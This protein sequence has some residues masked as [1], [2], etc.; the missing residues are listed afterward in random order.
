MK[1]DNNMK[2]GTAIDVANEVNNLRGV[3]I[4]IS[5]DRNGPEVLI[6]RKAFFEMFQ[7]FTEDRLCSDNGSILSAKVC[8]V[9]FKAVVYD[10][11]PRPD[12]EA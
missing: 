3:V 10:G 9:K 1:G 5:T 11:E 6:S 4:S 8:G 12:Q 7:T 2:L